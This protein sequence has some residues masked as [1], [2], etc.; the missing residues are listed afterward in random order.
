MIA[1]ASVCG[2]RLFWLGAAGVY[3]LGTLHLKSTLARASLN[4]RSV[5]SLSGDMCAV[6]VEDD[7]RRLPGSVRNERELRVGGLEEVL[8]SRFRKDLRLRLARCL[9]EQ[10]I[11]LAGHRQHEIRRELSSTPACVLVFE[12]TTTRTLVLGQNPMKER[13]PPVPPLC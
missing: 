10:A 9:N 1:A 13:S 11:R 5:D 12:S 7:G 2:R 4:L 6:L 8:L 3:S